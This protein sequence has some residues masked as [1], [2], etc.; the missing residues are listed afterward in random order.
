MD[1]IIPENTMLQAICL[2]SLMQHRPKDIVTTITDLIKN[3]E[4]IE[5]T[6]DEQ[7]EDANSDQMTIWKQTRDKTRVWTY[8]IAIIDLL[9]H[10]DERKYGIS[11]EGKGYFKFE[12]ILTKPFNEH[13][14]GQIFTGTSKT[15]KHTIFNTHFPE[16]R[17]RVNKVID[18]SSISR[19]I[20]LDI[21]IESYLPINASAIPELIYDILQRDGKECKATPNVLEEG[22]VKKVKYEISTYVPSINDMYGTKIELKPTNI[23]IQELMNIHDHSE[24][25]HIRHIFNSATK[26]LVAQQLKCIDSML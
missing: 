5:N 9:Q 18:A 12:V 4:T 25:Q 6:R 13:G 10:I 22:R 14:G 23:G 21:S 2:K 1:H 3:R 26:R 16:D 20:S 19:E 11:W 15:P 17:W 7:S 24:G 8:L